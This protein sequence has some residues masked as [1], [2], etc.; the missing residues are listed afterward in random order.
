MP[1]GDAVSE[2]G[3][4]HTPHPRVE[5]LCPREGAPGTDSRGLPGRWTWQRETA[6][7]IFGIKNKVILVLLVWDGLHLPV[8]Y[9]K[10][11]GTP[12]LP[13]ASFSVRRSSP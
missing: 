4:T 3:S 2:R 8:T 9:L 5:P 10:A 12:S 11:G 1:L 13:G 6:G 7:H